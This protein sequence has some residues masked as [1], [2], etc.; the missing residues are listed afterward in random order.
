[1]HTPVLLNKWLLLRWSVQNNWQCIQNLTKQ[2][3]VLGSK[4]L[5]TNS[6]RLDP[7]ILSFGRIIWDSILSEQLPVSS[8]HKFDLQTPDPLIHSSV[9][10]QTCVQENIRT[11]KAENSSEKNI[12]E[13]QCTNFHNSS[14]PQTQTTRKSSQ[15][16]DIKLICPLPNG[17][18]QSPYQRQTVLLL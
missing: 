4:T 14:E 7:W 9:L 10:S 8:W 6:T 2:T 15:N 1:M 18:I 3:C 5:M 11:A 13:K 12:L 17:N 16:L